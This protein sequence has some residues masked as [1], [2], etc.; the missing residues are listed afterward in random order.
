VTRQKKAK[1][2]AKLYLHGQKPLYLGRYKNEAAALAA[3]ESAYSV[4][5]TPRK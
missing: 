1:Y 2:S 3:C 4:I 5:S